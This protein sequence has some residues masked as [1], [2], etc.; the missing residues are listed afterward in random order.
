MA[1]GIL[2]LGGA[3]EII[4]ACKRGLMSVETELLV[5][6]VIIDGIGL[7]EVSGFGVVDGLGVD[8]LF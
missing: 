5:G 1:L 3:G 8:R 6:K 2:R 7:S 4:F